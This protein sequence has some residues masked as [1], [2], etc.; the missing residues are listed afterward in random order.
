MSKVWVSNSSGAGGCMSVAS[1]NISASNGVGPVLAES[2]GVCL[3]GLFGLLAQNLC[4]FLHCLS[5]FFAPNSSAE[6]F[7]AFSGMKKSPASI[8]LFSTHISTKIPFSHAEA[9]NSACSLHRFLYPFSKIFPIKGFMP[10]KAGYLNRCP[11][12]LDRTVFMGS[13]VAGCERQ[14]FC[15]TVL[16]LMR[17][18]W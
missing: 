14:R 1:Q 13:G 9:D 8:I 5:F 2:G 11:G 6:P 17:S 15:T 4:L 10:F 16:M 3:Q 7:S 18:C 12:S